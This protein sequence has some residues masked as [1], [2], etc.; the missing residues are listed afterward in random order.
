MWLPCADNTVLPLIG[1]DIIFSYSVLWYPLPFMSQRLSEFAQSLRWRLGLADVSI[2]FVPKMSY[3]V[4]IRRRWGS[5][6][7]INVV[8]SCYPCCMGSGIV[9]L[10]HL[11][12]SEILRKHYIPAAVA[13]AVTVRLRRWNTRIYRPLVG[14]VMRGLPLLSTFELIQFALIS[15]K[16]VK[17]GSHEGW[18]V[19]RLHSDMVQPKEGRWCFA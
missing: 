6:Q 4:K 13:V 5:W 14:R 8:L 12:L 11:L 16:G 9:L 1:M 17:L 2:K 7:Y 18:I 19:G 15:V 10:K 3:G